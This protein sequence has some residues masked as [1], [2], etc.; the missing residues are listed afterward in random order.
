MQSVTNRNGSYLNIPLSW[1]FAFLE[2]HEILIQVCT[3]LDSWEA[4][5]IIEIFNKKINI[6]FQKS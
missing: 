3:G 2:N 4:K 6:I 5:M 1:D